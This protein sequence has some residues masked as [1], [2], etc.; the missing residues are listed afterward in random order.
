[1]HRSGQSYKKFAR[2]KLSVRTIIPAKHGRP[3]SKPASGRYRR[4]MQLHFDAETYR[5]RSQVETV[6]SMIKRRQG[7]FVRGKSE[8]SRHR[9]LHLMVLTH[10]V[11]ILWWA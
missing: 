1:M 9:E 2:D 6:M 4:L 10:N 8:G 5:Q 3:T 11:M 7:N